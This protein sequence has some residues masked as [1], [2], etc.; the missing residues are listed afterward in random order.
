MKPSRWMPLFLILTLGLLHTAFGATGPSYWTLSPKPDS[1][2]PNGKMTAV[3]GK[4]NPTGVHFQLKDLTITQPVAVQVVSV[5]PV[6]ILEIRAFKNDPASPL[7]TRQT[8]TKGV[9]QLH[10]RTGETMYFRI[11]SKDPGLA[12]YQMIVCVGPK[13]THPAS[14]DYFVSPKGVKTAAADTKEKFNIK[15]T[16]AATKDHGPNTQTSRFQIILIILLGL[17]FVVLVVLVVVLLKRKPKAAAIIVLIIMAA[18]L[19]PDNSN[20][21]D[22]KDLLPHP[23][24]MTDEQWKNAINNTFLEKTKS[25]FNKIKSADAYAKNVIKHAE[26]LREILEYFEIIDGKEKLVMANFSPRGMPKLPSSYMGDSNPSSKT[27]ARFNEING[28]ISKAHAFLENNF[29][30][31]KQTMIS[32]NRIKDLQKAAANTSTFAQLAMMVHG[33]TTPGEKIFNDK[34]DKAVLNGLDYLDK[35]LKEMSEFEKDTYDFDNWYAYHGIQFYNFM[36]N[37][38]SRK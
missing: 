34:Y 1:R 27:T 12:A 33:G 8:D 31:Y 21:G 4:T 32:T 7:V 19:L 38:Y 37:R 16:E 15:I 10:F 24:T 11:V 2:L 28:R 25:K 29:V 14:S 20:A 22:E 17:I 13:I 35:A 3:S 23:Y 30:V 18:A 6:K 26:T 9:A 36:L 5:D